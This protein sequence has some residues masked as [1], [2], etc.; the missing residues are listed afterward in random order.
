MPDK[1]IISGGTG[2]IGSYLAP[3]LIDKGFDVFILTRSLEKYTP[4][5][6]VKF[7][8][9]DMN[10]PNEI[11]KDLFEDSKA[12]INLA[13]ASL[14][15]KRWSPSYKKIIYNSRI[16]TTR[17]LVDIINMCNNPPECLLSASG[18][19]A[20]SDEGDN[21]ITEE[22]QTGDTFLADLCKEWESEALKAQEIGVRVVL[23]RNGVV[24]ERNN[25]AF[26]RLSR[27][28]K[29]FLGGYLG[30]GKQ[31]FPWIHITDAVNLT[32]WAIESGI[33]GVVNNTSPNPETN[34]NFSKKLAKALHRPCFIGIPGFVLKIVLG[35]FAEYLLSSHRV[36]PDKAV[37]NGF[38]FKFSTLD[39]A[40]KDLTTN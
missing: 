12:V 17:K 35:E 14:G 28:F 15:D 29:F 30:N 9:W 33:S 38:Q 18:T 13:G 5:N 20:Y 6:K 1:I 19:D 32:V 27:L 10:K 34:K 24:L 26:P 11:Y 25:G 23:S 4:S 16:D 37:A 31:W 7:I 3:A 36:V 8:K 21:I 40:L 39:E 22:S 2:S